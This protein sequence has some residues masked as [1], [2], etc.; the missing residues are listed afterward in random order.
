MNI[1]MIVLYFQIVRGS[2][3]T[4]GNVG[5]VLA[6]WCKVRSSSLLCS[7]L[8]VHVFIVILTTL[9]LPLTVSCVPIM[10][11][12]SCTLKSKPDWA[13][14]HKGA[15]GPILTESSGDAPLV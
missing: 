12:D 7:L 10:M 8:V 13:I 15:G 11:C 5:N 14:S 1:S 6:H 9:S 2:H 3:D 4:E